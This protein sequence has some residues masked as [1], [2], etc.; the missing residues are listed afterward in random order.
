MSH[1]TDELQPT[2]IDLW[3]APEALDATIAPKKSF[4]ETWRFPAT[5]V[6]IVAVII[7]LIFWSYH[8]TEISDLRY[9]RLKS[10]IPYLTPAVV[11]MIDVAMEDGKVTRREYD[12]IWDEIE[13][14]K[15]VKI[16][17]ELQSQLKQ[18]K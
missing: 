18:H 8:T 4:D 1:Q 6:C 5:V 7:G 15:T 13:K 10:Q 3:Q 12:G 17:S 11:S 16:K 9:T 14:T 2:D